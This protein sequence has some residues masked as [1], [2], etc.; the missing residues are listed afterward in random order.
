MVLKLVFWALF[1][2]CFN[3]TTNPAPTPIVYEKLPT[4][5]TCTLPAP[6]SG[7]GT[8]HGSWVECD[9]AAVTG[10][11][12][13]HVVIKRVS[14]DYVITEDILILRYFSTSVTSTGDHKTYISQSVK[15]KVGRATLS[16]ST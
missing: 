3:N 9:W 14:D 13:Y 5:E 10:A 6:A 4:A 2:V 11:A 7:S 1:T 16:S 8:H 15:T 12:K